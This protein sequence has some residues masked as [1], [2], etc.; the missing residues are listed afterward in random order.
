MITTERVGGLEVRRIA[1]PAGAPTIVFLHEGLG[2]ASA[3]RDFPAQLA[4]E[5]GCPALVYSR[6]GYGTSAPPA[7][8]WGVD[9]MHRAAHEELP[10]LLQATGVDDVV[11]FGHSD[12]ASIALLHAAAPARTRV[13]ALVL[14]APHVFVEDVT[15]EAIAA[16]PA[17]FAAGGLR[18]RLA[19]HHRDVATLFERWTRL[20]LSP[21]FR[22]WNLEGELPAIRTPVLLIQ[23]DADEYGTLAQVEA[24]AR[25]ISGPVEQ[26]VIAGAG[27]SPHR[28]APELVLERS[29]R[30]I[31][32]H[33]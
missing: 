3:W 20:W 25:G 11:L 21:E 23:G 30:F 1:G 31:R 18:E 8:P 13:R 28:D 15:V 14:E 33:L 19:R 32:S 9:F 7:A 17:A 16:L 29:A 2:S 24:I 27:H 10:A 6:A 26:V 22:G 12:G 5:V 4:A